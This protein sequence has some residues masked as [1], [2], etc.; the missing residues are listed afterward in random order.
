M[1]EWQTTE[2]PLST[3]IEYQRDSGQ[4]E[5]GKLDT[6]GKFGMAP[7]GKAPRMR[8]QYRR[9]GMAEMFE[10]TRWRSIYD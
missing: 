1:A 10:V 3:E 2:P 4:V 9:E 8:Q 6:A 7:A 5:T